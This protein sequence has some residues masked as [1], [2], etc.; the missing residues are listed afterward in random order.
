M[1]RS[2]AQ[3]LLACM[4]LFTVGST[5]A[6]YL[7]GTYPQEFYLGQS[8]QGGKAAATLLS[9]TTGGN[10]GPAVGSRLLTCNPA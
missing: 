1:A 6:Y 2:R 7:P 4:H 8:I 5:L 9:I 10:G 3:A